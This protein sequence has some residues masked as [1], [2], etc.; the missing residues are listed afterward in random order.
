M[1]MCE[2][3][4]KMQQLFIT[5][6]KEKNPQKR[7]LC[8]EE[9]ILLNKLY[10]AVSGHTLETEME[11]YSHLEDFMRLDRKE[12][13]FFRAFTSNYEREID[14]HDLLSTNAILILC[15]YFTLGQME[16]YEHV[17]E[18]D[19]MK[20]IILSFFEK[21]LK[22]Y[23]PIVKNFYKE[24]A[25]YFLP[26]SKWST[27][28]AGSNLYLPY[29][30]KS[31]IVCNDK[32][33]L[34]TMVTIVHELG[35]MLCYYELKDNI[36]SMNKSY[37]YEVFSCTFERLFINYLMNEKFLVKECIHYLKEEDNTFFESADHLCFLTKFSSLM[38][39]IDYNVQN[40]EDFFIHHP[41]EDI[42]KEM[43]KE[44]NLKDELSSFY[45][46]LLSLEYE[47]QFLKNPEETLQYMKH[48]NQKNGIYPMKKLFAT[49]NLSLEEISKMKTLKN[50]LCTK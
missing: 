31:I 34:Q 45:G 4:N 35:H 17:I 41:N 8:L 21:Y 24:D 39:D 15:D 20:E 30:K 42:D 3:E 36:D 13:A 37:F 11:K 12:Y 43:Y 50:R 9:V 1:A 46:Y 44:L 23:Y 38:L 48:L 16:E 6:I 2:L 7:L 28:V 25:F 18:K 47:Q 10:C 40:Y 49:S 14:Y 29:S 19:T 22:E 33:D 27:K 32:M 26:Y 5:L